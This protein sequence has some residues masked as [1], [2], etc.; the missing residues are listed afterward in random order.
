MIFALLEETRIGFASRHSE[1]DLA[2][3]L[4][5]GG[6]GGREGGVF[7]KQDKQWLKELVGKYK[8]P[9]TVDKLYAVSEK[10]R[11]G[12][13]EGGREGGRE[14]RQTHAISAHHPT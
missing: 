13:M 10:V 14:D 3:L 9:A 1:H 8:E 2:Q 6:G 12:G 4:E 11:E 5:G 7:A